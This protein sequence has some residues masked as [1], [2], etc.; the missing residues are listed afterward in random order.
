ME[1]CPSKE[2]QCINTL[3][4]YA[5]VNSWTCQ[6]EGGKKASYFSV[7]PYALSIVKAAFTKSQWETHMRQIILTLCHAFM[8]L[9][10]DWTKVND[11]FT[12][13]RAVSTELVS[14]LRPETT[15]TRNNGSKVDDRDESQR[16]Q[17]AE[18]FVA[19]EL[20]EF[21]EY[22]RGSWRGETFHIAVRHVFH[23]I[24]TGDWHKMKDGL[25]YGSRFRG[26][27]GRNSGS[28]P[29]WYYIGTKP[30]VQEYLYD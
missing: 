15:N 26:G 18:T 25:A 20:A 28:Q 12:A 9:A 24:A 29:M 19:A 11:F 16:V 5:L 4:R 17:R 2:P 1:F 13:A 8:Q 27:P 23:Q 30:S 3:R 22:F 6:N 7:H 21:A 10:S 14:V